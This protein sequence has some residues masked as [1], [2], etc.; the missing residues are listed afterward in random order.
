M[1]NIRAVALGTCGILLEERVLTDYTQETAGSSYI[2]IKKLGIGITIH[3]QGDVELCENRHENA[4]VLI[5]S[6]AVYTQ[7]RV[8]IRHRY[9]E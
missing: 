7:E 1:Q 6:G 3:F 4:L 2:N 5:V 8:R 9:Q